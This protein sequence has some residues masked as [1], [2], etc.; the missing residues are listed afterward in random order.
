MSA[1][2]GACQT[3]FSVLH[4]LQLLGS[5]LSSLRL[6]TAVKSLVLEVVYVAVNTVCFLCGWLFLIAVGAVSLLIQAGLAQ[7]T[8]NTRPCIIK[9]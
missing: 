6:F 7:A 5:K 9:M 3:A 4:S 8:E 2:C 1:Y